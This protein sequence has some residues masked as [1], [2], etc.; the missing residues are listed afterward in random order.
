[1]NLT[2]KRKVVGLAA[3]AAIAPVLVMFLL[4]ITQQRALQTG[5]EGDLDDLA[6]REAGHIAQTVR[7]LC[8]SARK[9]TE[10]ELRG[11]LAVARAELNRLGPVT[12]S[13]APAPGGT[14]AAPN[15]PAPPVLMAGTNRF[16]GNPDFLKATPVVDA[17][18]QATRGHCTIFQRQNPDGDMVAV[19]TTVPGA[20]ESRA[21]GLRLAHLN[22]DRSEDPFI[23]A[24]LKG[25]TQAGRIQIGNA[26]QGRACEPIWDTGAQSNVV[27]MLAVDLDLTES[28]RDLRQSIMSMTVGKSGYV[29]VL[30]GQGAPR[31]HYLV[32]K[33]GSRDGEDIWDSRDSDGR[34]FIQS[35][36]QKA[37]DTRNGSVA[38]ERYAW[39]N[40]GEA[41]ARVKIAA[42]TY[43]EPWDWVIAAGMYEDDNHAAIGKLQSTINRLLTVGAAGGGIVM[44]VSVIVA[45]LLGAAMANPL[46]QIVQIARV[47]AQGNLAEA[48]QAIA[49]LARERKMAL[50]HVGEVLGAAG[51]ARHDEPGQLLEAVCA[52]THSLAALVGQVQKSSVQLVST[53]T[54]I[55]ATSRQQEATATDLGSST[56]EVAAAVK[57]I[58]ATSQELVRT[59][60]D[61]QDVAAGTE[62]LADTGRNG[63]AGMEGSMRQLAE[64]TASISSKL[65]VINEKAGSITSLVITITKVADQ[66]NLLSLNAAIEA[67]KAGEHGLGFAV[68]AREIRRLADQTAVA[69]LDIEQTVKEMQSSVSAGVMEM[70]KFSGEVNK[71]VQSVADISA[72][73]GQIIEQVKVLTPRFDTVNQGMRAQSAGAQQISEAMVQL[74]QGA[75]RTSDSLR[76]FNEATEQLKEAARGLQTAV[77]RFK[78]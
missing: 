75:Q 22:S 8:E 50:N 15:S 37:V 53:A 4:I 27:G 28:D 43:Y 59:M 62:Q 19:A 14:V 55:A 34:L 2:L 6:Q 29:Y 5:V 73:L 60:Q 64:A 42:V 10:L 39:K 49:A 70:D 63:L 51:P 77:T 11:H 65:A 26:W 45:L 48:R 25:N 30:G 56:T 1:M 31:G 68:V 38:L 58:S 40:P 35:I 57:E 17:V 9:R 24:V 74:S 13:A 7:R 76:Q 18:T 52:M 23:A 67:E 20:K 47:I 72:Q 3:T 12:L 61:V 36:I 41:Q 46:A 66:T 54:E 44:L 33:D 78:L 16:A 32:S 69:S 21:V 71:G